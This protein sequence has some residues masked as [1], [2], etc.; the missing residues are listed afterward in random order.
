[1]NFEKRNKDVRFYLLLFLLLFFIHQNCFQ[2]QT[3][4][5]HKL[6]GI[7]EVHQPARIAIVVAQ[8]VCLHEAARV[9]AGPL[10]LLPLGLLRL[11]GLRLLE[12]CGD[13]QQG[14]KKKKM[15]RELEDEEEEEKEEFADWLRNLGRH[16]RIRCTPRWSAA[17]VF[18]NAHMQ[19]HISWT[20]FWRISYYRLKILFMKEYFYPFWV[21]TPFSL[22]VRGKNSANNSANYKFGHNLLFF[23]LFMRDI[24]GNNYKSSHCFVMLTSLIVFRWWLLWRAAISG[25]QKHFSTNSSNIGG[26][27]EACRPIWQQQQLNEEAGHC[28]I[29][30]SR[31]Q[32]NLLRL[33]DEWGHRKSNKSIE[34]P[35]SSRQG[36]MWWIC[37]AHEAQ[38]PQ[39]EEEMRFLW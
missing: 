14:R 4:K 22:Y 25:R 8:T 18:G 38:W 31:W 17:E 13:E 2:N 33:T 19:F 9:G 36:W 16:G 11:L 6:T 3:K 39:A 34:P 5:I 35:K 7:R 23:V 1:M 27:A 29:P 21:F 37:P 26:T 32:T 30:F 12:L 28:I 15:A 24:L 10:L 20:L